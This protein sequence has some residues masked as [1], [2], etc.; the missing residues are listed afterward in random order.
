MRLVFHW[1]PFKR[2]CSNRWF[3]WS[4]EFAFLMIA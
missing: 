2:A 1:R 4:M 3:C